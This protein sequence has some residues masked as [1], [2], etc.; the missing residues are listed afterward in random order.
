MNPDEQDHL[1]REQY[2]SGEDQEHTKTRPIK[3]NH[4][5]V[6]CCCDMTIATISYNIQLGRDKAFCLGVLYSCDCEGF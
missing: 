4:C 3:E 1:D 2:F 5:G 6:H